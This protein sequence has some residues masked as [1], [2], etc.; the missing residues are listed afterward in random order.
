[1]ALETHLPEANPEVTGK[2]YGQRRRGTASENALALG[3]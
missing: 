1:M 2:S 3:M